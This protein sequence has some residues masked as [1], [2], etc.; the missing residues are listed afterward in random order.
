MCEIEILLPSKLW[1]GG[2]EEE[3]LQDGEIRRYVWAERKQSRGREEGSWEM[4]GRREGGTSQREFFCSC[5][6]CCL[7]A[8]IFL[9]HP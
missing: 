6:D 2:A 1:L 3:G 9:S 7:S 8:R 4:I 5:G